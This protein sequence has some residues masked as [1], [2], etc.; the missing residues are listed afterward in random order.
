MLKNYLKVALRN[1]ARNKVYS[2]I[3]IGGLAIGIAACMLIFLYVKDEL[4]YDRHHSKADRIYRVTRDFLSDDG[5]VSLHLARVAPP[6]GPLLQQ[7]FPEIERIARTLHTVLTVEDAEKQKTFREEGIFFAEPAFA[8]IFDIN[9]LKG[10][11]HKALQEPYSI[12][13]S[14]KMAEKYYPYEEAVGKVLRLNETLT[15]KVSAVFKSFPENSHMHPDFLASFSTLNDTTVYGAEAL[16]TNYGNNSFPTYLLLQS[17]EQTKSLQAQLPA[18]LDRH[19]SA[20]DHARSH[21]PSE[22]T[23]LYLQ[24]LT[25]IHLKSNLDSEL[26]VNGDIDSIMVLGAVAIVILL[27]ASINYVNLSTARSTSR[28]KEVGVRKVIGAAKHNLVLQ[29]L[30]ESVLITTIATILALGITELALPWLNEFT[31]KNITTALLSD[32]WVLLLV[33]AL[34]LVV[35]VLAGLY[36]AFYLSHFQAAT[37]LKGSLSS[38]SKNPMLRK[39]LVVLQFSISTVLIIATGIIYQQ[40]MYMQQKDLGF[41]SDQLVVLPNSSSL[42]PKYEAFKA[43]LMKSSAIQGAGRSLLVPTDQLLNSMGAQVSKGGSMAPTSTTIKYVAVDHDMLD[44]YKVK[45]AAGRNFDRKFASDDTAAY[46]VNEAAARMIGWHDPNMAIGQ[47]LSYG[48]NNGRII[49]VAQ[50]FHFESLHKEISPMVFMISNS[51]GYSNISVKVAG[52]TKEALAH[53]EETWQEF[54][55]KVPF[56]Y[57]FMDDLYEKSYQDEA[58][59]GQIFTIF[60]CIAI[61]IACLGLFGLASFTT[62]QRTK[63][64]GVR[65]VFGASVSGIVALISKDFLKLVLFA[66]LLAWPIAWYAMRKWLSDFAYRID[67][68]T[69][70][71][72]LATLVAFAVAM[73]TVSYQAIK[74]ASSNPV[75]ALRTE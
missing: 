17:D 6:F 27:I 16:K 68:S 13:L 66:N 51:Q 45:M 75:D 49:G 44:V 5:S 33:L 29:F 41:D 8:D 10:S 70:I 36:P 52:D 24:K 31:G 65:K 30:L 38:S 74:A 48:G 42:T 22:F 34:P 9:M 32:K 7:D 62:V 72:L 55:P 3:N 28:A 18:F 54:L 4:S 73:V 56:S 46:I 39:T 40:L 26:E 59:K 64:I 63:E 43:E 1:L 47:T 57:Q 50:D 60:S 23:N 71:F 14:D 19:L 58:K 25:D 35:G 37:V 12:L 67:I 61:V 21:K 69:D 53:I 20:T 15:F 11:A 2:A